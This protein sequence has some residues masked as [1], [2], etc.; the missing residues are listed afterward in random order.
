MKKPFSFPFEYQAGGMV[1]HIYSAP[2]SKRLKDGRIKIHDSFLAKYYEGV[3]L[4]S[5]RKSCW[6]EVETLVDEVVAAHRAQDPERLELTGMDRRIYLA[7]VAALKPVGKPVDLAAIDFAAA[8]QTLEPFK[9]D[10]RQAA[11]LVADALTRLK[12]TPIPTAVDF[13]LQYGQT[14]KETKLVPAV[15]GELISSVKNNGRGDYHVRDLTN[16]LER[17]SQAFPGPIHSIPEKDITLWLQGLLKHVYQGGKQVENDQ[18]IKVSHRTRN[19]YRD[20]IRELFVFARKRGYLPKGLPTAASESEPAKVKSQRIKIITPP[21]AKAVL[22]HLPPHLVPYTAIKLFSGMRTKEAFL[23]QW[24]DLRFDSNAVMVVEAENSK[25]NLRRVPQMLSNLA[26][27]L[28]PFQGLTGPINPDYSN[29]GA[30]QSAVIRCA[31]KA[32]VEFPR[33]TFRHC[34]ISYRVAQPTVP[35]IVAEE[36]GTSTAKIKSNYQALA[37]KNEAAEW[38]SIVPNKSQVADFQKHAK[39][40]N[41]NKKK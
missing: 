6:D 29:E 2:L 5:K 21:Q 34:Y 13:F 1:F 38:F 7:A 41:K 23:L 22:S 14:M 18:D 4:V 8:A 24:E 26:K 19:N 28:R 25:V 40:L 12:D 20:A 36:T 9:L 35:G 15:V 37:T 32:G 31:R 27:W 30:L 33:N 10:I 11:Q 16:R 39:E 17:F 3:R